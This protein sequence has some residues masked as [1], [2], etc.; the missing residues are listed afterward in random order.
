LG[1]SRGEAQDYIN[2]Y[3]ERYPGIKDYMERTKKQA[4]DKGFVE[5]P[6]GRRCHMRGINEKNQAIRGNAE[7]AAINAPIQGGAA[8]IIKRA[9]TE[10]PAALADAGMGAKMLLQVHDELIFEVPEE[11]V[12]KTQA[13]VKDVMESAAV[14]SVPLEVD[15]GVGDNWDEA[16]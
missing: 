6:F 7:R 10:L 3:F 2:A 11:E 15:I 8:D 1:I 14:L 16:H 4:H 13:L 5:T 9:M 12:E